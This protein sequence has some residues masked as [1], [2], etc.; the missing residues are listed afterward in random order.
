[1]IRAFALTFSVVALGFGA[2]AAT[3]PAAAVPHSTQS[4][5]RVATAPTA[6]AADPLSARC[7]DY[8]CEPPE[9]CHSCSQD[10]GSCCGN[11]HCEPPEDC[12][13]CPQDCGSCH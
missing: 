13:S 3:A 8:R 6:P 12:R 11:Y 1:M 5:L 7:G 9:D 10:C 4:A 2:H